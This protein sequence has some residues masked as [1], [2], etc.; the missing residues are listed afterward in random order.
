VCFNWA[1]D[2]GRAGTALRILDEVLHPRNDLW[3]YQSVRRDVTNGA[4]EGWSS[5]ASLFRPI[6]HLMF[7][8][9]LV[10]HERS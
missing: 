6:S 10:P 2:E 5:L 9:L 8:V 3:C 7:F 1:V 4:T